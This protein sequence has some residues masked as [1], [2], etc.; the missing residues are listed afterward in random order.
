MK[1]HSKAIRLQGVPRVPAEETSPHRQTTIDANEREADF[2]LPEHSFQPTAATIEVAGALWL[3][4]T[5]IELSPAERNELRYAQIH[6]GAQ[7]G[8]RGT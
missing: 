3:V 4:V 5:W 8:F 1:M 7:P 6:Q 2:D